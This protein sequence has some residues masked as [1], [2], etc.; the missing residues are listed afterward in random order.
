MSTDDEMA[1]DISQKYVKLDPREHVLQRSGMY[2]GSIINDSYEIWVV[3]NDGK[4]GKKIIFFNPGLYKIFDEILVNAIDHSFRLKMAEDTTNF[5]KNIRVS[6][7]NGIVEVYNDGDSIDVT[8]HPEHNVYVPELIFGNL[9]TSTN[10]DD[11]VERLIGGT[12][13]LGSKATNIFSEWFE[14]ECIDHERKLLYKQRFSNNLT[15]IGKP[16][17]KKCAKKP[18]TL[19][20]FKPDFQRFGVDGFSE[21]MMDVLRKRTY[22]A[23]AVTDSEVNVCW[24]EKKLEYKTFEKY[25]DLYLG[26][27]SEHGRAYE[28]I[29][30]RWEVAASFS[31]NGFEQ[32]SFVNGIWTI[33]GGKHVDYIVQQIVKK[34]SDVIAKKHKGVTVK[35]QT[36]KDNL[37]VFV[38][39]TIVN[40]TFDSQ[41]KETL[42]TTAAKFGSKAEVSDAFIT[43][44]AK[45]GIVDR[46]LMINQVVQEKTLAKTDGK[47]RS[48]IRG[49]PKLEDANWAGTGKSSECILILTEGDSAATTAI[50]GLTEVG[51]DRYGVFPL[52]GKVLNVQ[53][54]SFDKIASNE[55][56]TNIKK[57]LGLESGKTYHTLSDLR[58]GGIMLLTDADEDGSHIRGLVFNLFNTLWPSLVQK[59][60]FL[61]SLLTPIVKVKKGKT[62]ESFYTLTDYENWK[63]QNDNGKG[64]DI[65]YYK[66]LGTSTDEEAKQYFREM[67]MIKY[68]WTEE[69]SAAALDLAFNKKKADDRKDW[70]AKYDRQDIMNLKETEVPYETFVQKQ[71]IHFSNY[72]LERSIPNV[73]DGLKISQRKVLFGC[74]KKN[75]VDKEIKV[76]QLAGYVSEQAS[77]HHGEASLQSTIIGMAQNF[78]GSNNINLLQPNGQFGSRMRGGA[79]ASQPRYIH[80]LLSQITTTIFNKEDAPL[81]NYLDDDGFPIQPEYYMPII[82]MILVNGALGIGTGFSTNIPCFNPKDIINY[83]KMKL[84]GSEELPTELSPWYR[85]FVGSIVKIGPKFYSKGCYHKQ[86][87]NKIV[88]TELPIGTWTFD[89]KVHLEDMLD[90]DPN[91]KSYENASTH[92][93]VKFVLTFDSKTID[94]YL[95]QEANGFTRFENAF[96]MVTSKPLAI[97]NMYAFNHKGQIHKYDT[98]IDILDEFYTVRLDFYQKRKDYILGKLQADIDLLKNKIRFVKSVVSEEIKV[99]KMKKADLEDYLCKEKY[100]KYEEKYDYLIKIPIYNFT[101]DMV[102]QLEND[103]KIADDKYKKIFETDAKD[104]WLH[105]LNVLGHVYQKNI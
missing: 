3:D 5:V 8:V 71:L 33:R 94:S 48:L 83:L 49:L 72:D 16:E 37:V 52:K 44:L 66:G 88:V 11:S 79:D 10:Y 4:S 56:I 92:L 91:F 27:K 64:W 54:V 36:I 21:D 14:V 93:K 105:E 2:I 29:N 6:V 69:A 34:L 68:V 42:T 104:M 47:K 102:S 15:E 23:C 46:V 43:K 89:F 50:A 53:D 86:N 100:L 28:K 81:L 39:A 74:F 1:V 19:I 73:M 17:I 30:D 101:T 26:A 12:N 58:Y 84:R 60:R 7:S 85:G 78:V 77:Y 97:T 41:S 38:K 32:I 24:N 95:E 75:L 103:V 25:V 18:Y 70:L 35:P 65:K 57:I 40:P 99:H 98:V 22:D 9:M 76:A 45:T 80:T 62:V 82:P 90:K 61:Q 55:E 51:R 20:R 59:H 87:T 31:E 96:K 67:K 13:G 63:E